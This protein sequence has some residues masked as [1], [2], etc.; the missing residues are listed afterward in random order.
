MNAQV[1]ALQKSQQALIARLEALEQNKSSAVGF[2]KA[3]ESQETPYLEQ[4][5]PNG[6]TGQTSIKYFVPSSA[7]DAVINIYNKSGAQVSTHKITE[8]GAG[9]LQ[10]SA[11][12]YGSG[13]HIYDLVIDGRIIASRKMLVD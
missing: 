11:G 2:Q 8:R 5:A 9:E 4:N 7:K 10:L 1:T 3:D 6:F 13:L 12:N